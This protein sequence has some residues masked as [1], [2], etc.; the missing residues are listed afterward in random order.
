MVSASV[1]CA[2]DDAGVVDEH[3]DTPAER[4]ERRSDGSVGPVG[5]GEVGGDDH[6]LVGEGSGRP[7]RAG[8]PSEQRARTA[9]TA[10][11]ARAIAAPI[12]ARLR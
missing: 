1:S 11:R 6:R 7:P 4:L 8:R 5:R 3:I 10:S 2:H 9:P 12:P